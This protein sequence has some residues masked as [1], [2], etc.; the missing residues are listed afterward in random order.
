MSDAVTDP[1]AEGD[2]PRKLRGL[3]IALPVALL[4][5]AGAFLALQKE[6]ILPGLGAGSEAASHGAPADAD[7][8]FVALDPIVVSILQD[9][10]NRHLRVSLQLEVPRQHEADVRHL[11]PRVADILNGYL[12]ALTARDIEEPA[13]LLFVRAHMLR[14]VELVVGR[15]RV[16]DVLISEFVVN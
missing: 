2:A 9:P 12:Q 16:K 13:A 8:A 7:I 10:A 5:G 3:L 11:I 6:M 1:D 4:L 14:R 15:D